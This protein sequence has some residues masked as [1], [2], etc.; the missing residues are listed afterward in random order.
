MIETV[1]WKPHER[2]VFFGRNGTGRCTGI[3]VFDYDGVVSLTPFTSKDRLAR[4]EIAVPASALSELI[5]AL[6][7][8]RRQHEG[9][10]PDLKPL[11][12]ALEQSVSSAIVD[13]P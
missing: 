5:N 2:L 3:E 12:T 10:G 6:E 4:C 13:L 8:V 9:H 1:R 11:A 7:K